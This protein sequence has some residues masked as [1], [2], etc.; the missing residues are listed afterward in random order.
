MIQ[1][2]K[3]EKITVGI[4]DTDTKEEGATWVL[5]NEI[6]N[7]IEESKMG[8]YIDHTITQFRITSYNVCYT[9]LLRSDFVFVQSPLITRASI[10]PATSSH[11]F[12]F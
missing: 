6:G 11:V 12:L 10:S 7:L 4:D 9:K 3:M 1:T 2:P 8:F 5:A